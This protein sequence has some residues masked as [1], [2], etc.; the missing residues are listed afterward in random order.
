MDSTVKRDRINECKANA[1]C[2]TVYNTGMK[3]KLPYYVKSMINEL[4][5]L[6]D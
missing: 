6:L 3:F 2:I 1:S 5:S 4:P